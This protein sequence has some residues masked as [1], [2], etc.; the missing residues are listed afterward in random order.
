MCVLACHSV[1][2]AAR[3]DGLSPL[4]PSLNRQLEEE[5]EEELQYTIIDWV[6]MKGPFY[7]KDMLAMAHV[8]NG[9][10]NMFDIYYSP[11]VLKS[12]YLEYS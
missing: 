10:S 2:Q 1:G 12:F 6:W 7:D 8:E 5:E 4:C 9:Y 11:I 3:I